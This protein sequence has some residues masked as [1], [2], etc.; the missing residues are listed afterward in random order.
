[1][2]N[3]QDGV[4]PKLL[5]KLR[6]QVRLRQVPEDSTTVTMTLGANAVIAANNDLQQENPAT[7]LKKWKKLTS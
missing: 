5:Q 7:L 2:H 3:M 1:M 6:T 4:S